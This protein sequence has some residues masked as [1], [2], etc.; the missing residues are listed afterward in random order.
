M[1]VTIPGSVGIPGFTGCQPMTHSLWSNPV[2][3]TPIGQ[4]LGFAGGVD[5]GGDNGGGEVEVSLDVSTGG[6]GGTAVS[7][8]DVSAISIGFVA[9]SCCGSLGVAVAGLG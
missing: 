5:S 6:G 3:L 2:G 8:V 1:I 4:Q 9:D 7:T